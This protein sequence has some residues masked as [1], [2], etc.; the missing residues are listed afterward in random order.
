M[1]SSP[2]FPLKRLS[3]AGGAGVL[4]EALLASQ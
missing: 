2:S 1:K 3:S 4:S